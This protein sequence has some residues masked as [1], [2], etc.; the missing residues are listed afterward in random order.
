MGSVHLEKPNT[1]Y[2]CRVSGAVHKVAS[3]HM[4]VGVD[5]NIA[6]LKQKPLN[7]VTKTLK[8]T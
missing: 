3:I 6:I 8:L 5:D 1:M 4:Y 7:L 2:V